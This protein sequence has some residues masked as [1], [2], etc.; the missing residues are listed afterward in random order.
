M[1]G[2]ERKAQAIRWLTQAEEKLT[3][4]IEPD[5]ASRILDGCVVLTAEEAKGPARFIA[6]LCRKHQGSSASG[7]VIAACEECQLRREALALLTPDAG[8]DDSD[9]QLMEMKC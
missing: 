6:S 8:P 1:S 5:T 2:R 4:L 7:N 3:H 9:K